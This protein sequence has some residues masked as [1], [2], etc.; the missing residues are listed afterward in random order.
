MPGMYNERF[1]RHVSVPF[2][3]SDRRYWGGGIVSGDDP[4]GTVPRARPVLC[5]GVA[6]GKPGLAG[7]VSG[8]AG[9]KPGL[10]GVVCV[11]PT[12]FV[13]AVVMELAAMTHVPDIINPTTVNPMKVSFICYFLCR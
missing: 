10:V 5:S 13:G 1:Y 2:N 4:G 6:G 11:T 12:P 3:C 8:V 9:A 7:I